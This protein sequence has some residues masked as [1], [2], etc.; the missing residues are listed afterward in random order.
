MSK[1]L[2][3]NGSEKTHTASIL[4]V[5]KSGRII[6]ASDQ[7]NIYCENFYS[8]VSESEKSFIAENIKHDDI[9]RFLLVR[10]LSG[11]AIIFRSLCPRMGMLPVILPNIDESEAIRYVKDGIFESVFPSPSYDTD[12]VPQKAA[13]KASDI[14]DFC[15][16][17]SK[18]FPSRAVYGKYYMDMLGVT[19]A[20]RALSEA[21]FE[22][23]GCHLKMTVDDS[24]NIFMKT[25]LF[26]VEIVHAAVISLAFCTL[27]YSADKTMTSCFTSLGGERVIF[28]ASFKLCKEH[29]DLM[30][31]ECQEISVL[32]SEFENK[33][34]AHTFSVKDG[35][36]EISFSPYYSASN[37]DLK[38][39]TIRRYR[40]GGG[41]NDE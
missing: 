15:T 6:S 4:L 12:A 3:E 39:Y 34:I 30:T 24:V 18:A 36:F 37:K 38:A 26:S 29:Y 20:V 22:L 27:R 32:K 14:K 8:V 1:I 19:D 17:L 28:K 35:V 13:Y 41:S 25:D 40:F 7:S 16:L 31:S 33:G 21:V 10:T 5:L 9:K 11:P 23:L 2:Y